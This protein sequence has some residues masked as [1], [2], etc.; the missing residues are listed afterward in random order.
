MLNLCTEESEFFLKLKKKKVQI[1]ILLWTLLTS[2]RSVLIV[3][4]WF[5]SNYFICTDSIYT[6][7]QF[8]MGRSMSFMN[9]GH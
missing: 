8:G 2:Q 6:K 7:G 5:D 9:Q 3:F 1:T 4:R